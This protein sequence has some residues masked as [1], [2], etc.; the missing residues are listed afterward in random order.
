MRRKS[1]FFNTWLNH[2]IRR[3]SNAISTP[4]GW[5]KASAATRWS[6]VAAICSSFPPGCVT[7]PQPPCSGCR[8]RAAGL[9]GR[10][11][12]CRA[13]RP[14]HCPLS[15]PVCGTSSETNCARARSPLIRPWKWRA[16]GSTVR[17]PSP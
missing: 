17:C 12:E 14:F 5:K 3:R 4:C 8:H 6:P 13:L 15:S 11:H 16:P 10:V 9:P 2:P 1:R 7:E